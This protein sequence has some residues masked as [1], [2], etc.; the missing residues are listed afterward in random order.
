MNYT[1]QNR[2]TGEIV[3]AYSEDV[4]TEWPEYPFAEFNHIPQPVSSTPMPTTERNV[5]GVQYLRRF[6]QSER[7]AIRSAASQSAELDDYLKLLD[8][9]I[10]QGGTVNLADADTVAAVILLEHAGLLAEGRSAEI[11]A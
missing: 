11:L 1:V 5:S 4:A 2:A 8:T 10:A 9:T 3:Y 7:I 6:T